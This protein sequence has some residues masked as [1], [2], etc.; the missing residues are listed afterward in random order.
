MAKKN[1][2][3]RE[4]SP[5]LISRLNELET[6]KG[7]WWHSL[8]RKDDT[9][10]AIRPG[11]LSVY[12]KGGSLLKI[13]LGSNGQLRCIVHEEYLFLRSVRPYVDINKG[14]EH[15]FRFIKNAQELVQHYSAVQRRIRK[16][17]GEE[18][19]GVG[20]IASKISNVIDIEVTDQQPVNEAPA[21]DKNKKKSRKGSIDLAAVSDGI[22][23][24][25]E[26]KLLSNQELS[27]Q[28]GQPPIIRQ[29]ARYREWIEKKENKIVAVFNKARDFYGQLQGPLFQK[30]RKAISE[31]TGVRR[32]P[33][34]L[35]FG[36]N[37]IQRRKK[38]PSVLKGLDQHGIKGEDIITIGN[39][40]SLKAARLFKPNG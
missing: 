39:A 17:Q 26:A 20:L 9:F 37:E 19:H 15:K 35:I 11:Y 30:R 7:S 25:Y 32:R 29:V 28:K 12:T 36:F 14:S 13:E 10:F 5:K 38:L 21:S 33:V 18:R 1:G 34:L 22:I 23:W 8:I 27:S 16:S 3:D 6:K 40:Q 31:I 24:F 2:F 4:L